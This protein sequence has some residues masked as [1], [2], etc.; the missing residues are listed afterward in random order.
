V[1]AS[2]LRF[3]TPLLAVG[4]SLGLLA[5]STALADRVAVVIGVGDYGKIDDSLELPGATA[6]AREL[7]RTL[8]QH[9][10]YDQVLPLI[11]ALATRSAIQDLL[12]ETLPAQL[13]VAASLLVYFVGH[14]VGGDFGEPYLLPY[15]AD[16]GDLQN[17]A[18]SVDELGSKLRNQLQVGS[19]VMVT[20]AVHDMRLDDLV[21]V[22]PNAKS[23]PE[24]ADEF[25]SL[26]ACSPK[27]IP[28]ETPFGA[29]FADGISGAADSTTDGEVTASE[30]YRYV[31]DK[32]AASSVKAHPAESGA[33]N[34][35]LV[36]ARVTKT[37]QDFEPV[38]AEP[39]RS[40]KPRRIAGASLA[41]VGLGLAGG[42]LGLYLDGVSIY[43]EASVP[44]TDQVE[45]PAALQAYKDRYARDQKWAPVLIGAGAASLVTGGVLVVLPAPGGATVGVSMSF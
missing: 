13:D 7:A 21:L 36:V 27:E 35:E 25:F 16:P 39:V 31:I 1:P 2:F 20:D 17:T 41:V 37:P 5:P 19:L 32:M 10:G 8:E 15:D 34:P 42:G 28:G 40:A 14:G 23:W 44:M 33:Y 43:D 30:L 3:R 11:D 45:D 6:A 9:A 24:A 4:L 22:G 38:A 12:L 18:I 29:L 26:S